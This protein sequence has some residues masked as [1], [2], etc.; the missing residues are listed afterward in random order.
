MTSGMQSL[1]VKRDNLEHST[2][3]GLSPSPT[4][5]YKQEWY[6]CEFPI[7]LNL[8]LLEF[9]VANSPHW[10][11]YRLLLG[12]TY[13]H[14]GAV[15]AGFDEIMRMDIKHMQLDSLGYLYIQK[16][17]VSGYLSAARRALYH[18]DSYYGSC[19]REVYT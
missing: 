10:Y 16:V 5:A 13:F 4:D 11:P 2:E 12:K 6:E 15:E 17:L 8:A 18:A 19:N 9:G 7:A 14:C 1:N 3:N